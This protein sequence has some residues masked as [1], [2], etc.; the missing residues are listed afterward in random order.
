[1]SDMAEAAL[2]YAEQGKPVLPC[3]PK[4]KSPLIM[5]GCHA[6][7]RDADQIAAWWKRWPHA[8]IGM[9]TGKA[10]G[11][12]VLDLDKKNGKDGF[13][14]VPDWQQL[15]TVIACT[16]NGGAHLY[17]ASD[18]SIASTSDQLASGVDTRGYNGYV[19]VPPSKGYSWLNGCD[20]SELPPW[21]ERLR[22]RMRTVDEP[23]PEIAKLIMQMTMLDGE[24]LGL[25]DDPDDFAKP[26][27]REK[28]KKALYVIDPDIDR[29][30]WFEIGCAL[31]KELGDDGFAVWDEWSKPG[32]KY[33]ARDIREQWRSIVKKGYNFRFGTLDHYATLANPD[34]WISDD[35]QPSSGDNNPQP[36]RKRLLLS[37]AEFVGGFVPPDYLIDGLLQR[38]Y[39]YSMTAP[40][41]AGKTSIALRM[42]AHVSLGIEL[43]ADMQVEKGRVLYFAGENPDDVRTRW[44]KQC[45]ELEQDP[46]EMDV[47][48]LPGA[49]AIS[50]K[51]IRRKIDA[52][53]AEHGPFSLMIVDTSA[54]YFR[55]DDENSN[56]QLASHARMMR[57]FVA[58]PGGP[59]ILVTCHPVKNPNMEN[60][61]PRGGGAFLN[62]VD[63]NL[64]CLKEPGGMVVTLDTHGKFR[65][66]EF[67]P[68]SF[69][70]VTGT[71][72]RLKDTKGRL[73]WT[74]TAEPITREAKSAL[75]D[76]RRSRQDELLLM[77]KGS[78]GLSLS[79]LA[80]ALG[81]SYLNGGPNVTMVHR[82]MSKLDKD[83]LVAKKRD[84]YELTKKGIAVVEEIEA[85]GGKPPSAPVKKATVITK[86]LMLHRESDLAVE[87]SIS[88]HGKLVWL[89]RSQIKIERQQGDSIEI[90]MPRWMDKKFV[91]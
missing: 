79:G 61:L 2:R 69:K 42:A 78:P 25:S 41:G 73:V 15:S 77:M 72:E 89:A 71:S 21:P 76:T 43:T 40:T 39:V 44:I 87:V 14:A 83:K 45:E 74:V 52:E 84:H 17:F 47:I 11:I 33:K 85:A 60:L 13:A 19:I 1:M 58:L 10:S 50:D 38:R 57:S 48:F 59:T 67:E 91:D 53:A 37:S 3:D 22:P 51:E 55:G 31:F 88:E 68:F 4:D 81:W 66:P 5:G 36:I 32:K 28:I 34:W 8:L 18:G 56:A 46:A 12:D 49:P 86:T 24:A 75:E 29:T 16:M 9:P 6:A 30:A 82:M 20:L 63:G 62:E 7:T 26:A 70:L 54:A 90:T 23:S 27:S 80:E 35:P 65:G 64:V